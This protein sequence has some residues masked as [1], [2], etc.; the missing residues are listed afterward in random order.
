MPIIAEDWSVQVVGFWNPSIYTPAGVA[1]HLFKLPDATP[2]QVLISIDRPAP[3]QVQ[4]DGLTVMVGNDRLV[5]QPDRA[6]FEK[7][8][9]AMVIAQRA[10]DDLPRTPFIAAGFNLK[11][12]S[13]EAVP[14]LVEI[15]AHDWDNKLSDE[16]FTIQERSVIRSVRRENGRIN[17]TVT[18]K[19]DLTFTV[20]L[21]FDLQ[22]GDVKQLRAWIEV[23]AAN[24]QREAERVLH[25]SMGVRKEEVRYG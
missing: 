12:R 15:T 5:V 10:L 17:V 18:Q 21:N 7:I 9:A 1:R 8:V 2:V 13:E 3:Y 25:N 23:A 16:G 22:S 24:I 19:E 11:F 20:V 14:A 6:N 4:H